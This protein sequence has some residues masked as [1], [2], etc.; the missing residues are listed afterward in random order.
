MK[1]R[2]RRSRIDTGFGARSTA[3]GQ[4]FAVLKAV[5]LLMVF[6][7]FAGILSNTLIE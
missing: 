2:A 3:E 1:S 5:L 6:P 7:L 4:F